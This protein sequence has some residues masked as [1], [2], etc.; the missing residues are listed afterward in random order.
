MGLFSSIF[1]KKPKMPEFTPVSYSDAQKDSIAMNRASVGEA[2]EMTKEAWEAD[3]AVKEKALKDAI[4]GYEEMVTGEKDIISDMMAGKLPKS[5]QDRLKDRR[6]SLGIGGGYAGTQFAGAQTARDLGISEL[7]LIQQG[8]GQSAAYTQR[9][10]AEMPVVQ[11][12]Y[13]MFSTPQQTLAHRTSER[14][15]KF[16]RDTAASKIAAAPSPVGAGLF[17]TAMF[18]VGMA[19]GFGPALSGIGGFLGGA[20]GSSAGVGG[21][22]KSNISGITPQENFGYLSTGFGKNWGINAPYI[23]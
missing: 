1:G 5:V 22:A 9:R 12:V 16:Q 19:G 4:P 7:D 10:G 3:W 18:G 11:S 6:A 8:L 13:S 23:R 20:G 21:V 17:N 15:L 2:G 14:N